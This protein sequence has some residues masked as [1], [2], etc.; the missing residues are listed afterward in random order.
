MAGPKT[1]VGISGKARQVK[2][3]YVGVSGK[4]RKIKKAYVGVGGKA[5]LVYSDMW[6]IPSA[7]FATS[8]CIAAYRFKGAASQAAA[9]TDLTGHGYTLR[10]NGGASWSSAN[11][12]Y[13]TNGVSYA[14]NVALTSDNLNRQN[15]QAMVICYSGGTGWWGDVGGTSKVA[16]IASNAGGRGDGDQWDGYSGPTNHPAIKKSSGHVLLATA[17]PP[18]SGTLGMNTA[19]AIYSNG[20]AMT[21]Q[22]KATE[23]QFWFPRD[24]VWTLW[25][26]Q[27]NGF[28][29]H[30]MAFYSVALSAVQ[31]KD[32]SQMM[33]N[34]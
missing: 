5:R 9:L 28:K 33:R 15:V 26:H 2:N 19:S 4:A 17:D 7:G 12:F 25:F 8:N 3:I 31:H 20:V 10:N 18:A 1:F 14:Y 11:G 32:V 6:W 13:I 16:F 21:V 24:G 34:L 22:D 29:L 30:A 23:G 27:H